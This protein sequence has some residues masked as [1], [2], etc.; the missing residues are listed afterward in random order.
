[1]VLVQPSQQPA[2]AKETATLEH[3]TGLQTLEVHCGTPLHLTL[4]AHTTTLQ[5]IGAVRVQGPH[6]LVSVSV[7]D[8][9]TTDDSVIARGLDILQDIS[10]QQQPWALHITAPQVVEQQV[11]AALEACSSLTS[12]TIAEGALHM[13]AN[14][15][16]WW[17]K[18]IAKLTRL[19]ELDLDVRKQTQADVLQ[20]TT[21]TAIT[22]LMIRCGEGVDDAVTVALSWHLTNLQELCVSGMFQTAAIVP[23]IAGLTKLRGLGVIPRP[24]SG[25]EAC[26]TPCLLNQLLALS[27]LTGLTLPVGHACP[28]EALE[29]FVAQMTGL[30]HLS[31]R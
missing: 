5:A 2:V 6:G 15:T 23:A 30:R 26:V 14:G 16:P 10:A 8:M 17:C 31:F 1:M 3:L 24:R 4:P 28:I 9:V 25:F 21:L 27:Q 20:L 7:K 19:V 12:L 11:L 29:L 13:A 18:H 22:S